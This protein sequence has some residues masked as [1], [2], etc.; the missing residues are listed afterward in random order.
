MRVVTTLTRMSARRLLT[1]AGVAVVTTAALGA[2]ATPALA[3]AECNGVPNCQSISTPWVAVAGGGSLNAPTIGGYYVACPSG[4]H[5]AGAD[6]IANVVDD[7][8]L[9]LQ[10]PGGWPMSLAIFR[11]YGTT[12]QP[13]SFQGYAGCTPSSASSRSVLATAAAARS[14]RQVRAHSERLRAGRTITRTHECRRG[15]RV[16]SAGG[17]VAFH[18]E[19]PPSRAELRGQHLRLKRT[20]HGLGASVRTEATVGD[21]EHVELQLHVVCA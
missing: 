16:V 8:E 9:S 3:T 17:S 18:T 19:K 14:G 7:V 6:W 15:E 20:T 13:G 1:A 10:P 2:A 21:D 4:M 12:G 11:G 5:V